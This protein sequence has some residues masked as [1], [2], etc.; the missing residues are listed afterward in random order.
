M[1]SVS[2][3]DCQLPILPAWGEYSIWSACC[4]IP[5]DLTDAILGSAICSTCM[6]Q[7]LRVTLAQLLP[8]RPK[9]QPRCQSLHN[10]RYGHRMSAIVMSGRNRASCRVDVIVLKSY[11]P[12][13]TSLWTSRAFKG[14]LRYQ[15]MYNGP[16][17]SG[18]LRNDCL[19]IAHSF[20]HTSYVN[21]LYL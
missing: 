1:M 13:P 3:R 11:T 18:S 19:E 2:V 15:I 12:S 6:G 20:Q 16:L 9:L 21:P 10:G 8:N 14:F 4:G 17:L 5:A 7:K